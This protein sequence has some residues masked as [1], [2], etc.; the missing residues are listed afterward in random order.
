MLV[1]G[2]EGGIVDLK[3]MLESASEMESL[4]SNRVVWIYLR[5]FLKIHHLSLNPTD[6]V[7]GVTV[8]FL[9]VYVLL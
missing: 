7:C 9:D 6:N 4:Q 1:I 2:S 3:T 5:I 8:V